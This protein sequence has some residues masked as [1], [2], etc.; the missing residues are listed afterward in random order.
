MAYRCRGEVV[1]E[2]EACVGWLPCV[3][4]GGNVL[5]IPSREIT[6]VRRTASDVLVRKW[7]EFVSVVLNPGHRKTLVGAT[8]AVS[9]MFDTSADFSDPAANVP[10]VEDGIVEEDLHWD[11]RDLTSK[12]DCGLSA[13]QRVQKRFQTYGLSV[14]SD[15]WSVQQ[16]IREA[17]VELPIVDGDKTSLPNLKEAYAANKAELEKSLTAPEEKLADA[18]RRIQEFEHN[19][20][21]VDELVTEVDEA[22]AKLRSSEE[23]VRF[24]EDDVSEQSNQL[25][26][27]DSFP[28]GY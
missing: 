10:I 24:L 9:S 12:D 19:R 13:M 15:V 26:E 27:K 25:L 7:V 28:H 18:E 2:E 20:E 14:L 5:A 6:T 4:S 17:L 11:L 23:H 3:G 16:V 21:A 8:N 1:W 22:D